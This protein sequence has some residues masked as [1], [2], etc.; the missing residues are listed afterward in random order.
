MSDNNQVVSFVHWI[1]RMWDSV[2]H[3]IHPGVAK[4]KCKITGADISDQRPN[5]KFISAQ[6]EGYQEA[7]KIRNKDSNPRNRLRYKI[8]RIKESPNLFKD[9]YFIVLNK[10]QKRL[11]EYWKGTEYD[12]DN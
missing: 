11:L 12:V 2:T 8:N 6:K 3:Q 4:K 9:N 10:E 5:S 7:Q 1:T